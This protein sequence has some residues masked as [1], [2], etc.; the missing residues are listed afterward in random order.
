MR[1][2]RTPR[3]FRRIFPR[4][5]WGFSRSTAA[6]YLTF[7]DGPDPAVT[8]WV[9]DEL[10]SRNAKATFFCVGSQVKKF[11]DLFEQIKREGHTVGNHTMNHENGR[12]TDSKKYLESI[13]DADK[14][15]DSKLFRPPYGSISGKQTKDVSDQGYK[16]IMWSWLTY[17]FDDQV[18]ID[19]IVQAA[20]KVNSGDIVV[21]HDNPKCFERL[22][23]ILPGVLDAISQKGL[24][25][26]GIK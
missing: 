20:Q 22:K 12:K 9:L 5:T 8:P 3:F 2:Y 15:I 25:F 26:E 16:I 17:D 13:H 18:E 1:L 23:R 19:Q 7:D 14:L 6:V 4:M 11:P 10:R 21:L 24:D